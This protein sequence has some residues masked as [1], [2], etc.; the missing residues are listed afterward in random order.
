MRIAATTNYH[1]LTLL[2]NFERMVGQILPATFTM[3]CA[4]IA[5][6]DAYCAPT[7]VNDAVDAETRV[8]HGGH[9]FAF[10]VDRIAIEQ[11]G[12]DALAPSTSFKIKREHVGG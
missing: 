2:L 4:P 3:G 6:I 7:F 9:T 1:H 12:A 8:D 11:A 5:R 10:L